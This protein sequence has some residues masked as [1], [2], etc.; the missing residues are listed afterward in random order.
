MLAPTLSRA[1][2]D[3]VCS[4]GWCPR[5]T[6]EPAKRS[7]TIAQSRDHADGVENNVKRA[8]VMGMRGTQRQ[9]HLQTWGAASD[10]Q[11]RRDG[12]TQSVMKPRESSHREKGTT[13]QSDAEVKAMVERAAASR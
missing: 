10:V 6:R 12:S 2:L 4:I 3:W 5:T 7:R 1:G 13:A 11:A 8:G 9:S